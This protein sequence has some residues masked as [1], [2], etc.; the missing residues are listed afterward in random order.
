ML[1]KDKK[2]WSYQKRETR[3]VCFKEKEKTRL[4]EKRNKVI[5]NQGKGENEVIPTWE[6][7]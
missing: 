1:G 3:L 7:R 4:S 5:P 6:K 2:K